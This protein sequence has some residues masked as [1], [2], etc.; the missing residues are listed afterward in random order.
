MTGLDYCEK[1]FAD[2]G[3]V[4][5]FNKKHHFLSLKNNERLIIQK[6]AVKI[7]GNLWQS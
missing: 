1:R 6:I 7:C 5:S 3:P 2:N 4:T